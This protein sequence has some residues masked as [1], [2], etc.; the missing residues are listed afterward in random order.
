MN[1]STWQKLR[2]KIQE[3]FAFEHTDKYD[4]QRLFRT[5]QGSDLND[6]I[7]EFNSRCLAARDLDELM[8]TLLFIEGLLDG[9]VVKGV[10]R[11]HPKT[12]QEA[13]SAAHAAVRNRHSVPSGQL[14]QMHNQPVPRPRRG[15]MYERPSPWPRI[16]AAERE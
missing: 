16:S 11:Y 12:L 2:K 13:F 9:E 7:F 8:K 14:R 1:S 4:R 6:F 5:R 15:R 10:E 3:A